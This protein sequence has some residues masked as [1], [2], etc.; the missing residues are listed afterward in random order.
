MRE[1]AR[2]RLIWR[3]VRSV[4]WAVHVARERPFCASGLSA[5]SML[6][7]RSQPHSAGCAR[8][9]QDV[10]ADNC[11]RRH[12]ARPW[13]GGRGIADGVAAVGPED[14][15]AALAGDRGLFGHG[16]CEGASPG[17]LLDARRGT[18]SRSFPLEASSA[19]GSM[20]QV[21]GWSAPGEAGGFGLGSLR[22]TTL[23]AQG[24]WH[25][26]RHPSRRKRP[27]LGGGCGRAALLRP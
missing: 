4:G 16:P 10:P 8:C 25:L 20:E 14:L 9:E 2:T 3:Q 7:A 15:S 6:T 11:R 27:D 22:V 21:G 23:L 17:D 1:R 12:V 24:G 5:L 19:G 18:A 26:R 13:P